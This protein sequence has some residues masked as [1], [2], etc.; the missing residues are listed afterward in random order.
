MVGVTIKSENL[1]QER[2]AKREMAKI[3]G[4]FVSS[5]GGFLFVVCQRGQQKE[6]WQCWFMKMDSACAPAESLA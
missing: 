3:R 2:S 1:P 5:S 6:C 4:L